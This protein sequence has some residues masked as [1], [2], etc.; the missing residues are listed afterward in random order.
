MSKKIPITVLTGFLGSGKT[1]LVNHILANTK[2][3]KF[4]IIENEFGAVGV[5]DALIG[6]GRFESEEEVVEMMNGCICCTVR[7]DLVKVLQRLL[8]EQK[9]KFDAILIETTGLADPA[10]VAQTF[11]VEDS[12]RDLCTLDA[13][14]TVVDAKHVLQ[15]LDDEKEEGVENEA[16]EQIAFADKILL[17]KTDLVSEAEIKELS[18]RIRTINTA[19]EIIPCQKSQVDVQ[20]ILNIEGFSL[21]RVMEMEPGF[22]EEEGGDHKHD[23][24]VSS[25][26]LELPEALNIGHLQ[27]WIQILLRTLGADLFRYKGVLNVQGMDQKF[28]FQG[29]HMLFSGTFMDEWKANEKRTS[30]FVFIGKNLDKELLEGGFRSCIAKPLRFD[31]GTHV[32]A[33]VDEDVFE[34]GIVIK[35]W[36]EGNPYR[37]L[38]K[39]GREVWGPV[40]EDALV[41]LPPSAPASSGNK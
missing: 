26:A 8:I 9:R 16:V 18:S 30:K 37:I 2:G 20:K 3:L 14:I 32:Q 38:L 36:D 25:V 13:I 28:V 12:I 41:R 10:P 1:T 34:D 7:T 11:F 22:L 24:T 40:D 15:H 39:S 6:K 5:D 17:N 29:I 35:L 19:A 27:H 4:A 33:Y 31:V 21:E 23:S